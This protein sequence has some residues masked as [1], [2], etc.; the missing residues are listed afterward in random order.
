M[1]RSTNIACSSLNAMGRGLGGNVRGGGA[2]PVVV[3]GS[4]LFSFL[5]ISLA[6]ILYVY[7]LLLKLHQIDV[8]MLLLILALSFPQYSRLFL[9]F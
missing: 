1:I 3:L 2:L 9:L 5:F 6:G 4:A 8:P 7:D